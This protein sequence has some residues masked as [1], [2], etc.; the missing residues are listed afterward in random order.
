[1]TPSRNLTA[2][3]PDRGW[4]FQGNAEQL[5]CLLQSPASSKRTAKTLRT[6]PALEGGFLLIFFTCGLMQ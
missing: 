2:G 4:Q 6:L 1:M 3:I 5:T